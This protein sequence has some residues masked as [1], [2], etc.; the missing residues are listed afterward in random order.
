M[1]SLLSAIDARLAPAPVPA[2]Y[3]ALKRW[4]YAHRGLHRDG[5]PENSLAAFEG[6]VAAGLGIECDIQRSRD[7][8]PMVF[9]DWDLNRLTGREGRVADFTAA[10]LAG[11][12]L[13]EGGQRIP[14]LADLLA[15]VA[16][17]VPILIEIKSRVGYDVETSCAAVRDGL[18]DYHGPVAI[19]SFDPRAARWFRLHSPETLRGLVMEEAASGL[20]PTEMRRHLALWAA[21][22]DFLAYDVKALP[23]PFAGAQRVRGLPLLTWTVRTRD[24]AGRAEL[25]ADAPI[26]EGAG[27]A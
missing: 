11:F 27:L 1:R 18:R 21:K 24:L 20:T 12:D 22:P 26:A 3:G 10:E 5:V 25:Y 6:A 16:G 19:M 23:S 7:D 15:L 9:H 2:R 14:Q 17:R 4:T 13:R 8:R